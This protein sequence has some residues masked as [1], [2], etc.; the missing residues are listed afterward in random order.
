MHSA[1]PQTYLLHSHKRFLAVGCCWRHSPAPMVLPQL[2]AQGVLAPPAVLQW[3]HPHPPCFSMVMLAAACLGPHR[4]L[5]A[6]EEGNQREAGDQRASAGAREGRRVAD[7]CQRWKKRGASHRS[8]PKTERGAMTRKGCRRE[9]EYQ[10]LFSCAGNGMC[11]ANA[12][13]E[14]WMFYL[15]LLTIFHPFD[16][17]SPCTFHCPLSLPVLFAG[18]HWGIS[19]TC[20]GLCSRST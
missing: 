6:D 19:Y 5:V 7:C 17:Q 11:S 4:N 9:Q 20:T 13:P 14:R 1:S 18:S 10:V 15:L 3:G 12:H 2:R 8:L 16:K